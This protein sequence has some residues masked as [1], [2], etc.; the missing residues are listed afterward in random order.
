MSP[1]RLLVASAAFGS[2]A[3]STMAAPLN[4]RTPRPTSEKP[5]LSAVWWRPPST[6]STSSHRVCALQGG[7][8]FRSSVGNTA[9][10]RAA[11][12]RRENPPR[13]L[14]TSRSQSVNYRRCKTG[15]GPRQEGAVIERLRRA[16]SWLTVFAR[17]RP[18]AHLLGGSAVAENRPQQ[19]E[20]STDC[21]QG[22][23]DKRARAT[24][25]R[26]GSVQLSKPFVE[27]KPG[28][29]SARPVNNS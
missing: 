20:G 14:A 29:A 12:E 24:V 18:H 5:R 15:H 4:P 11:M 27:M 10:R 1:T 19:N 9:G 26:E 17:A 25:A 2:R 3:F 16:L 8:R 21:G 28:P 23:G 22:G 6:K 13:Q 7:A